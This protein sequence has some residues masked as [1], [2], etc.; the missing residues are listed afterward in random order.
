MNDNRLTTE[1]VL[2]VFRAMP[3]SV[4]VQLAVSMMEEVRAK[5][6]CGA[7]VNKRDHAEYDACRKFYNYMETPSKVWFG[8][9]VI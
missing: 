7:E 8:V 6:N 1:E 9:E 5:R 2:N 4:A 3:E